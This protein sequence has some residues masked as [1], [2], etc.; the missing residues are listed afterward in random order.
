MHYL[1]L[2]TGDVSWLAEWARIDD[3]GFGLPDS[4]LDAVLLEANY[5][6]RREHNLKLTVEA[7][8]SDL[9]T[10][11]VRYRGSVVW[12]YFPWSLTQVRAGFRQIDSDN[13]NALENREESFVQ[14]H[15]FF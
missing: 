5:A 7:L 10:E 13:G 15:L 9:L 1:G 4:T 12:E 14:L 8:L 11:E 2:K 3:D 6:V